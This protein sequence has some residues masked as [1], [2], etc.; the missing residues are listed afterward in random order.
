[1][2]F[3]QNLP[4]CPFCR[5][6][7]HYTELDKETRLPD[8][9]E[10]LGECLFEITDDEVKGKAL[11]FFLQAFPKSPTERREDDWTGKCPNPA[12]HWEGPSSDCF[13]GYSPTNAGPFGDHV[14]PI[15]VVKG[16]WNVVVHICP[17]R[18]AK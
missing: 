12:C 11:E 3:K 8:R 2:N 16:K 10:C 14:C 6:K 7:V 4:L 9:I 1:M 15:C 18:R 17:T 5:G 13:R